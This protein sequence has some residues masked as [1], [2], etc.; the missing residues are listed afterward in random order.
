[1]LADSSLSFGRIFPVAHNFFHHILVAMFLGFLVGPFK[2]LLL[3][4]QAWVFGDHGLLLA[5]ELLQNAGDALVLGHV[6]EGEVVPAE[7]ALRYPLLPELVDTY[8]AGAV[9]ERAE[10]DGGPV[11]GVEAHAADLADD[12]SH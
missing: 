5:L 11:L 4:H 12:V 10:E 8:P 6:G 1:M 9:V 7:G 3:A 2:K